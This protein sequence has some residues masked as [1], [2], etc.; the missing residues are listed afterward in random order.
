MFRITKLSKLTDEKRTVKVRGALK[1]NKNDV[2]LTAKELG[3]STSMVYRYMKKY[4][5]PLLHPQT[6][7]SA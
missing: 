4:T 2:K 5:L 3:I 6:R 7:R 1:R